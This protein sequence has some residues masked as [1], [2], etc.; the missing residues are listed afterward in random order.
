MPQM[1]P[2]DVRKAA[3][4]DYGQ[5]RAVNVIYIGNARA[6]NPDDRVPA[7]HVESELVSLDDVE[8]IT[9]KA[10]RETAAETK[11]G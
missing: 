10:G 5:Y 1:S 2:E 3:V 9:T 7:S 8:K 4:D 6:F 11:K